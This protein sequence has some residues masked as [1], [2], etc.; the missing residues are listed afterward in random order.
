MVSFLL[1]FKFDNETGNGDLCNSFKSPE[2]LS[3]ENKKKK[4]IE[5]KKQKKNNQ[6]NIYNNEWSGHKWMSLTFA[7]FYF[8]FIFG[9][10][11]WGG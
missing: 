3:N 6:L 5:N 9:R 7:F 11:N 10:T 1:I 4:Q 8:F 2:Y